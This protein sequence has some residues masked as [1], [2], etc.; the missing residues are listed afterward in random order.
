MAFFITWDIQCTFGVQ[1]WMV[2]D[3]DMLILLRMKQ[4]GM[5]SVTF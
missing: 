3:M 1:L 5:L 2:N 4:M